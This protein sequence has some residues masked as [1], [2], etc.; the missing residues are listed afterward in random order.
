M[1]LM[2][3]AMRA[4]LDLG[5]RHWSGSDRYLEDR[6]INIVRG[7]LRDDAR[8]VLERYREKRGTIYNG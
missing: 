2:R 4:Q 5:R 1:H 6:G 8:S 3:S 7:V